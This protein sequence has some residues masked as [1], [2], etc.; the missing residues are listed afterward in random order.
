MYARLLRP[1]RGKSFFLFGPRGTGKTSWLRS[2]FPNALYLDLL[3]SELYLDL[4]ARPQRLENLIPSAFSDWVILD[5][6]QRVPELLNE[7]HRLIEKAGYKFILTGSSARS[8]RRKGVNLLAGRALTYKMYPLTCTEMGADFSL[9]H[10]LQYGQL[11]ATFSEPLPEKYLQS[12]VDTYLREEV[13]QEGLTR[14]AGA[15]ARF[16]EVSSLSQASVLN[17]SEVAR[18][19]GVNRKVAENY[20]EILED[21]LLAVRLPVFTKK[22][23]R[24]MTGHSKFYLADVG[25]FRAIRPMGPLDQPEEAEG[26]SLETLLFQELRAI[27]DYLELGYDLFYWRTSNQVEVD[28]V[29]YGPRGLVALEIKRSRNISSKDL[30]GLRAFASDYPGTRLYVLYGGSRTEEIDGIRLIPI[31][32]AFKRL[33]LLLE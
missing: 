1:P 21:L 6:V 28:F 31:E 15:F 7:V 5:E 16:L 3:E 26:A 17:I 18:E 11:P 10:A 13:I 22:A 29:L 14:N 19:A 24:R 2:S 30:S 23:K 4:S 32:D 12:Y 25:I 20:F 8:L 33:P 9:K 27:N